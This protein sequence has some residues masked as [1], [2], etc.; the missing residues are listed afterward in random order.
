MQ[1]WQTAGLGDSFVRRIQQGVDIQTV[2]QNI[3][4][5]QDI[6]IDGLFA[7]VAWVL[8]NNRNNKVWNDAAELG[9]NI[10]FKAKNNFWRSG[11]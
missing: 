2:I 5:C 3:C 10:G 9:R 6:E 11:Y 7:M 1:A 4:S 8:C